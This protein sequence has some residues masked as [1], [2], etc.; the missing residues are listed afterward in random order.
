MELFAN[1]CRLCRAENDPTESWPQLTQTGNEHLLEK[2]QACTGV[3]IQTDDG[4]P[5]RICQR[6]ETS[7]NQADTF[8]L[9]CRE[10]DAWW[11]FNFGESIVKPVP[12][13]SIFV[14]PEV[15]E[16]DEPVGNEEQSVGV[17][18]VV[19]EEQ[20]KVEESD[21]EPT[22]DDPSSDEWTK[23]TNKAKKKKAKPKK[24]D[25][26]DFWCDVCKKNLANK[27]NFEEHMARHSGVQNFECTECDSKFYCAAAL[28]RHKDKIHPKQQ[29]FQCDQCDRKFAKEKDLL[30]HQ[31]LHSEARPFS[32]KLCPKAFKA[33][34]NLNKHMQWVHQPEEVREELKRKCIRTFVC[35]YC[36]K[37]SKSGC[38]HKKHLLT[39]T[40]EKNFE[41]H[42]CSKRFAVQWCHQ[43]HMLIHTGERPYQCEFCQKAFREKQHLTTHIR[44]V[45]KNERP[46]PCRFCPKAFVTRQSMQI[47]EK[48]HGERVVG[49][50]VAQ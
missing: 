8:R 35:P 41:C 50:D 3:Q 12:I 39:H 7:L 14:K 20:V 40:G 44:G 48:T 47:H 4:L 17:E 16:D 15:V 18:T 19:K 22:K 5:K 25:R 13:T 23:E 1:H 32:C 33:Q 46:F 6:C 21:Y 2:I 11:R 26:K 27:S 24:T 28:K 49:L 10:A 9:Q 37:I 36:G 38:V 34:I 29:P 30:K 43:K 45:H 42:I 31:A